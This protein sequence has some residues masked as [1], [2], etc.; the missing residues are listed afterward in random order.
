[1]VLDSNM[2]ILLDNKNRL[3]TCHG[4]FRTSWGCSPSVDSFLSTLIINNHSQSWLCGVPVSLV[5]RRIG[6]RLALQFIERIIILIATFWMKKINTCLMT[7]D[8]F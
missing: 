2:P 3:T 1:M 5:P 4:G 8:D 7:S 6:T